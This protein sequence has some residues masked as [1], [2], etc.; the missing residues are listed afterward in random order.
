[1][2]AVKIS[3][4]LTVCWPTPW[5]MQYNFIYDK[6]CTFYLCGM[7]NVSVKLI[8]WSQDIRRTMLTLLQLCKAKGGNGSGR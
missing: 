3:T 7:K 2:S 4:L 6:K 5:R 1:M 8:F